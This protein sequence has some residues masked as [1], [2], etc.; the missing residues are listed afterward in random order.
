[1]KTTEVPAPWGGSAF[2][3]VLGTGL[4]GSAVPESRA[5]EILDAYLQAGGNVIDTANVYAEWLDGGKGKSET[6]LGQW[7]KDSGTRERFVL[8]TKG[9]HADLS[10]GQ[11]R[12]TQ[13]C[14]RADLAQSLERLQVDRVDLYWLHRDDPAVPVDEILGWMNELL[15]ERL[16]GAIGCSN[17][18]WPRI[19][20]AHRHAEQEQ[21]TGFCA[22]QVGW[23]LAAADPNGPGPAGMIFMDRETRDYHERTAFPLLAYSAQANGF[24]SGKYLRG[25]DPE[26]RKPGVRPWVLQRYGSDAN[27]DRLDRAAAIAERTGANAN[28]VAL[29]WLLHQP[30]PVLPMIGP[31]TVEQLRQS[32]AALELTLSGEEPAFL[33]HGQT[34]GPVP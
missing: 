16:I 7:M 29:A 12:M 24:F 5:F 22:S 2:P 17:W 6:T 34:D 3:F 23:S 31:G 21:V 14:L 32:L 26:D 18:A 13:D 19:E 11:S 1:M 10:T 27:F 33:E 15:A 8:S 9:A 20:E 28:Q 30:F 25:M 4:F